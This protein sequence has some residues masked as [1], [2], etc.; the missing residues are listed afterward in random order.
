MT[1]GKFFEAR[2]AK[3]VSSAYQNLGSVIGREPGKSEITW[4]FVA[5]GAILLTAAAAFS[6]LVAPR[7]P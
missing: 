3:A 4:V 5:L 1:G 7:L 2:S 6:L